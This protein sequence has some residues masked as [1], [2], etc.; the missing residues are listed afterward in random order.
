MD[1]NLLILFLG[2]AAN[3]VLGLVVYLRNPKS[4][5]QR[6]F[7]W[8][9]IDISCWSIANYFALRTT[10]VLTALY[11]TRIVMA[12]AVPQAVL[13]YLLLATIP[14]EKLT[15]PKRNVLILFGFS[16]LA[17]I[18]TLSPYVFTSL[19]YVDGTPSPTPGPAMPV[20]VLVA[21]GSVI[22]G[23]WTVITR[24]KRSVGLMKTQLQILGIGI[25]FMLFLIVFFNFALVVLF[26][27]STYI[28]ASPL[29]TL[30]F[31]G[32]TAYVIIKHNFLDIRLVIARTVSYVVLI[33]LFALL[34]AL[35]FSVTS[36][37][38]V[39]P[40]IDWKFIG[41]STAA[42]LVMLLTFPLVKR[43]IEKATDAVFYKDKYD[44]SQV[45]YH[46]AQIMARSLRLEDLVHQLLVRLNAEMR[47]MHS[48]IVLSSDQDVVMVM[49]EGYE[50]PPEI[51][52]GIVHQIISEGGIVYRDA[53][54]SHSVRAFMDA[55]DVFIA[56]PLQTSHS[57]IGLLCIG[58]KQSGESFSP[59]DISTLEIIAP[60]MAVAVENAL[61]YEEIRRFNVTLQDEVDNATEDL[62]TANDRLRELDKLK[63]EFVSLASHELRTPLTAIRS[64]IWMMMSGKGGEVSDKQKYYLDRTYSSANRLIRLVNDMLNISRIE[65]GRM[66]VAFSRTSIQK[67]IDDVIVEIQP[68]IDEL[69]IVFTRDIPDEIPDVIADVDKIKEVLI[70]LLGNAMKF[71]SRGGTITL[72]VQSSDQWVRVLVTDS[73]IGFQPEDAQ[74]LFRK[75]S[76]LAQPSA[77][78]QNYQSTGLGLYISKSIIDMHTGTLR[79]SSEGVGKGATFEFTVP[80]YTAQKR[81]QMQRKYSQEGLGIIHSAV[82]EEH[83]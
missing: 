81:E 7:L 71:T 80:V 54:R 37:L 76:T 65:S 30:P 82:G 24:I 52:Q 38:L 16:V 26:H 75:F 20:F 46:L 56:L 68:K 2:V 48:C 35:V 21:V 22:A 19:I 59:E 58:S 1:I 40:F 53:V 11:L 41:I 32:A 77:Q 39:T 25:V 73:G 55:L 49:T 44:T 57:T 31:V 4:A 36:S 69:G 78:T 15:L 83:T 29:Y 12:L 8:F 13:F 28:S 6:L 23:I 51:A 63:D 74:K 50:T 60:E 47:F 27:I 5:T 66:A 17:I 72:S 33:S 14:H 45:L 43:G 70:N 67:I 34:Y 3:L 42:A 64:Y 18:A 79:A 62:R 61:S 9:S 10:D